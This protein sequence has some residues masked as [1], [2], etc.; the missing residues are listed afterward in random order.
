MRLRSTRF[1]CV[2]TVNGKV[3]ADLE[4]R[5]AGPGRARRCHGE[6]H[7]SALSR[8][9]FPSQS[10]PLNGVIHAIYNGTTQ[11]IALN[12]SYIRT[13]ET[14]LNLNGE[15]SNHS[16][17]KV[18]LQANNLAELESI[19][20]VFQPAKPGQPA[21]PPLGLSGKLSFNGTVSRSL[22]APELQ[23]RLNGTNVQIHGASFKLLQADVDASPSHVALTHGLIQPVP[24]GQLNFDLQASLKDWSLTPQSP[25]Q[26][27]VNARNVAIA[28]FV[29]AADVTTPISGTLNANINV[30]GSQENPIGHGTVTLTN[31]NINGQ[32]IQAVN[33]DF[34]GTGDVVNSN[35]LVRT[36][37]GNA[38][39]KAYLLS[40]DPRLRGRAASHR[41]STREIAG[42][43]RARHGHRRHAQP[44][45]QR[46]RHA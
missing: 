37:A 46:K 42:C 10:I 16:A 14:T 3:D 20:N 32:T 39:W 24:Q 18:N 23:G 25:V 15:L 6:L 4:R 21:P 8:P 11:S 7:R 30:H 33:L 34:Q 9:E 27:Q 26:A 45:C 38:S 22:S 43:Q 36:A 1:R 28:P 41:Y 13:P 31:A 17:L 40:E 2:A 19:A 29:R 35:L 44:Y 5:D 12:N